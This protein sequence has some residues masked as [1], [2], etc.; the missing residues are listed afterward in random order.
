MNKDSSI[1]L[2]KKDNKINE[3]SSENIEIIINKEKDKDKNKE[4]VEEDLFLSSDEDEYQK[5]SK[6]KK[7]IE[8]LC[9]FMNNDPKINKYLKKNLYDFICCFVWSIY[10]NFNC[11]FIF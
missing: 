11:S 6:L 9:S 10:I 4:F 8:K 3:S 2:T 7:C 1:E 5:K